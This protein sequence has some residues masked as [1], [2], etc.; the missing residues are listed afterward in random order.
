MGQLVVFSDMLKRWWDS[1]APRDEELWV[2]H[3]TLN[4]RG[5]SKCSQAE[6]QGD[7]VK[8]QFGQKEGRLPT[9][10]DSSVVPRG[11]AAE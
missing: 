11:A 3:A 9:D 7:A 5:A 1:L 4:K 2:F 8:L 6:C 10:R